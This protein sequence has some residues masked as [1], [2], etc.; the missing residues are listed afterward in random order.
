[1][2]TI[3][4][5]V[6]QVIRRVFLQSLVTRLPWFLFALL[7]LA[8]I[9][10][11]VPKFV[12]WGWMADLDHQQL[13]NASWIWG[14]GGFAILLTLLSC[15]WTRMNPRE[16]AEALDERF[17][18]QQR[19]SSAM[20]MTSQ[21]TDPAFYN[22]LVN[23]AERRMVDL[24]VGE[25]FPIKSKWPLLL[26]I[27]PLLV[28]A[29]LSLVPAVVAP[30]IPE[31][32]ELEK[33]EKKELAELIRKASN[34]TE[35]KT[36]V[37]KEME[38]TRIVQQ[39]M[40]KAEKELTKENV[41]KKDA[42]V[43]INDVKKSIQDQQDKIG[44]ADALKDRL[45][46]LKEQT[47]GPADKMTDAMKEGKFGEASE[48]MKKLAEKIAKGEL[49]KEDTQKL[50]KQMEEIKEQLDRANNEFEKKK[51]DLERQIQEAAAE[52]DLQRAADLEQQ[53]KQ[54]EQQQRQM[55]QMNKMGQQ[56]QKLA[57]ALKEAQKQQQNGQEMNQQQKQQMQ[58]AMKEMQQQLEEMEMDAKQME[59]LQEMMQKMDQMKENM[60][61]GQMKGMPDFGGQGKGEGE[62]GKGM[63]EGQGKGD[64]PTNDDGDG[65]FYDSNVKPD[66]KP[67]EVARIGKV[68][69]ANRKGVSTAEI[70][71]A[72]QEAAE[73]K[74]LTPDE[75]QAI[76]YNQ[77]EHVR[78]YFKK[79]RDK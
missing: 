1:M 40:E 14:A 26:P 50:I 49:T 13:W 34:R 47:Q 75:L 28:L 4:Q 17:E 58:Q 71:A 36:D 67:G 5:K 66:V 15:W 39:A 62:P 56:M 11:G 48:Q 72:L 12:Y 61:D 77:R 35:N 21:T 54:L 68:G 32:A 25:K 7:L 6:G 73:N 20:R 22:A 19:T 53:K 30:E 65:N 43:A 16:A 41:S 31:L 63:G 3:H 57:D 52:G 24:V 23:D 42:M 46:Q 38:A 60:K 45:K 33:E 74:D 64:R 59:Q 69:G 10:I 70:E 76:P 18:L 79:V 2:K 55:Q 8:A 37:D 29:G 78:D 51:Q 27:I 9:A 44:K